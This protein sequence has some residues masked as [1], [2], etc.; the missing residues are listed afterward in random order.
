M[1]AQLLVDCPVTYV[2]SLPAQLLGLTAKISAYYWI[3]NR[4]TIVRPAFVY[5]R[6]DQLAVTTA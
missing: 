2:I 1:A 6:A 4:D 3:T 5:R